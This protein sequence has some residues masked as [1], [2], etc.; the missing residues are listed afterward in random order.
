L[1]IEKQ[2]RFQARAVLSLSNDTHCFARN[3]GDLV[4]KKSTPAVNNSTLIPTAI[5]YTCSVYTGE[6]RFFMGKLLPIP[7]LSK[8]GFFFA[9]AQTFESMSLGGM[10]RVVPLPSRTT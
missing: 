4:P 2:R 7:A 1:L 6:H 5:R 8:P 3:A 9:K 10:K